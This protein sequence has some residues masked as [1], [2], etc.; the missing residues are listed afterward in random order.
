MLQPYTNKKLPHLDAL[1]FYAFMAVFAAH[2]MH[3]KLPDMQ[4]LDVWQ[5]IRQH[6]QVGVLGVNFFFV[7]SG[8]LIT[9]LLILEREK[10]SSIQL[11]RFYIR[12]S[13]RI[14]PLY[15][16]ILILVAISY[17]FV[18]ADTNTQ[19]L[20][21]I[22][23]VGNFH[24]LSIGAPHSPALANLWTLGVE[25]QFYI[26][27]PLL[28][29]FSKRRST[30]LLIAFVIMLSLIFRYTH[31]HQPAVLYFHTLS[32]S[33]DF[34]VG[35][36]GAWLVI[37]YEDK[38]AYLFQSLGSSSMIIYPLLCM[39]LY[40]NEELFAPAAMVICE[41]VILSLMFLFLILEQLYAKDHILKAGKYALVNYLGKISYGLYMYHAFAIQASNMFFTHTSGFSSPRTYM[42]FHPL[43]ALLITILLA[44]FSYE[45]MEIKFLNLKR[46][47][48]PQ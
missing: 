12:R 10:N 35:A 28:L 44:A 3:I 34:A 45:C 16:S 36:L 9:R 15:F 33:S 22:F 41:R 30:L 19:W 20:Y 39:V 4:H 11:L 17:L 32:I 21:Y 31:L 23:F 14:W 6:L 8:F 48:L 42:L 18:K 26:L 38:I 7:L 43:T 13:L 40:F 47:F 1:R 24:S 29:F 46:H 27:W 2:T 25:E 37:Y 5:E